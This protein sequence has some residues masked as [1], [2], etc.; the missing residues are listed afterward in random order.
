MRKG[1]HHTEETRAIMGKSRLGVKLTEEHKKRISEG[2][3]ARGWSPPVSREWLFH[4]YVELGLSSRQIAREYRTNR[5]NI[6]HWLRKYGIEVRKRNQPYPITKEELYR[7]Y[8]NEKMSIRDIAR[9]FGY[10][11]SVISRKL[12]KWGIPARTK[13]EWHRIDDLWGTLGTNLYGRGFT[14]KLKR[15]VRERD[16]HRCLSC[17]KFGDGREL[18]IHHVDRDKDNNHLDNLITLCAVCH[19]NIHGEHAAEKFLGRENSHLL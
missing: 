16:C 5:V 10:D 18:H 15:I 4:R 11:Q 14:P 19:G 3:K 7:F 8:V 9:K 17:G 2:H 6:I 1:S 12:T 13:C